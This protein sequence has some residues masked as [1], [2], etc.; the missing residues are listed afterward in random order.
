MGTS[1]HG[2]AAVV[3]LAGR[4]AVVLLGQ[5]ASLEAV[6]LLEEAFL[7][8]LAAVVLLAGL[9]AVGLLD[10]AATP[11]DQGHLALPVALLAWPCRQHSR[12]GLLLP[13]TVGSCARLTK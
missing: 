1:P 2:L 6:A 5:A 9:V 10:L 7:H 8:G 11:A 3:F 4:A 13:L 12:H